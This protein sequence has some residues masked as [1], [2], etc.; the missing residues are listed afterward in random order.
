MTRIAV[1]GLRDGPVRTGGRHAGAIFL[2]DTSLNKRDTLIV[3]GSG[4]DVAK[5]NGRLRHGTV[6]PGNHIITS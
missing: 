4:V 2:F 1:E 5:S 3:G 6:M